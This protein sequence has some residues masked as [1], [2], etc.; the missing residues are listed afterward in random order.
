MGS[1][2]SWHPGVPIPGPAA[3]RNLAALCPVASKLLAL[4]MACP[5]LLSQLFHHCTFL[6]LVAAGHI[7]PC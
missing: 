1:L 3:R 2:G 4:P 7:H 6:V 5:G